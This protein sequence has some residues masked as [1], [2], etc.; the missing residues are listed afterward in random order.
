[1]P[2][3]NTTC[4]SIAALIAAALSGCNT[5]PQ[6]KEAR[7]LKR[8]EALVAQKDYSRAL[9]EFRNASTAVPKDAEPFYQMGLAYLGSADLVG[10]ARSFRKA[11][12]LNPNHTG[13]QLK[14]A[15]M[16]VNTRNKGLVEEAAKR[17][18][19]ILTNAPDNSE[20][21][22][23]LAI[24][25]W[26]LGQPEDATKRLEETL[27]KFPANL[28]SSVVL[29]KMKLSR[30]DMAGAQEILQKAV[31]TAP[32]S[33]Q[34]ALALGQVY[35]LSKQ[36]EKAEAEM[37]RALQLDAKSGAALL[38]LAALQVS[39]RRME[40][41]EQ[42]YHR[43]SALPDKEYKPLHALFLFQTGK[44]DA[45]LE[46]F[47][48]LAKDDPKDRTARSRLLAAY[49]TMGKVPEAQRLLAGALKDNPKDTDALFQR[50]ELYLRS[51]DA[52]AAKEDLNQVLHFK[53]DSAQAHYALAEVYRAEG[54]LQSRQELAEAL[55][56]NAGMLPARVALARSFITSNEPKSAL[57]VLDATPENQKNVL[58]VIV[59]RNWA[60]FADG[61]VKEMRGSLDRALKAG[62][63]PE[64]LI[65]DAVLKMREG[66][67]A[68]ARASAD[69]VLGR[70][71]EDLRAARI[72]VDSHV[73]QKE[74]L[75]ALGRLTELAEGHPKSAPLQ[76]LLGEYQLANGKLPE[77]RKAFE[78]AK[79]VDPRF[80][81]A[82]LALAEI[83]RKENHLEAA[84]KRLMT[85]VGAE[86]RNI[87]VLLM[88]ADIEGA[89]GNRAEAIARYRA[90]IDI[91]SDNLFA[92]NNLAY[93]LAAD[94]PDE[95]LK[96][97]Q[98]A[99]EIAPDNAN[100]QDTLGWIYYRKGVYSA[101]AEHLK[102]AVAREATPRRQ[103]H[104]GMAYLKTGNRELGQKTVTAAVQKDPTLPKTE[105]GW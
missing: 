2:A 10:A 28:Q 33:S 91:Q 86:P 45:A 25:E 84:R 13:A 76:N 27:Q 20:A 3:N 69:E 61:N 55:R 1:M 31:A 4:I 58:A 75:K 39:G 51:G 90:A 62:R 83:D 47:R 81:Q 34:A 92:L 49:V 95:A 18:E 35:W 38:G 71:S 63:Y 87:R 74:P 104:L 73:A 64:V 14:L 41:A 85:M 23:T 37:K 22:G 97:A 11:I 36:P 8:G 16:M 93:T 94:N 80:S 26:K 77:A 78:A 68:G 40:E 60:L 5:S 48:K 88:L 65:Q 52:A 98:R 72:L 30:N 46:E 89:T 32:Q 15:E 67:Y 100:V 101:A 53:S 21:I 59:E 82:E 42:T 44:R 19:T 6:A 99:V 79:A 105:Q 54:S 50:A 29:A 17:L 70:N 7:Y 57:L 96:Y 66:D 24:A 56:L 12:D 43:V 9:L 102:T 103:F